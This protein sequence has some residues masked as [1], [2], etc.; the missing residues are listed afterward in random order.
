MNAIRSSLAFVFSA[1]AMAPLMADDSQGPPL[2]GSWTWTWE[3]GQAKTHKHVLEVTGSGANQAVRERF[4]D[5]EAVK[6]DI[7]KRDG[8]QIRFSVVRGDRTANYTGTFKD[9]DTIEGK[10]V[11]IQAGQNDEFSWTAH[12]KV[13]KK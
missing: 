12:R 13:V 10:V 11:V 8:K 7:I 9:D 5:M 6:V 3:D 1:I 4:D 2:V